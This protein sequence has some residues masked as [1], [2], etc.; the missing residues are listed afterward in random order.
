[1]EL[2]INEKKKIQQLIDMTLQREFE[3]GLTEADS[4]LKLWRTGKM[5]YK[6]NYYLLYK[7]IT[8]FDKHIAQRY[9]DLTPTNYLLTLVSMLLDKTI[10]ESDLIDFSYELKV[11]L[12]NI[13]MSL[14]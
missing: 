3:R 12:K 7:H 6:E 8:E 5:N 2:S 4:I 9:D 11:Y 10:V 13:F 1:M 14:S